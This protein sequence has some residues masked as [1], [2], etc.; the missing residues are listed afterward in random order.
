MKIWKK[1]IL[2]EIEIFKNIFLFFFA[3]KFMSQQKV[4]PQEKRH[5]SRFSLCAFKIIKLDHFCVI[6][7]DIC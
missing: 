6:K 4:N 7:F 1:K 2:K 3:I 5:R